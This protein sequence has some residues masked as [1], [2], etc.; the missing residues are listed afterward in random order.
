[1]VS[2]RIQPLAVVALRCWYFSFFLFLFV[3]LV[4]RDPE[5]FSLLASQT[6]TIP[7]YMFVFKALGEQLTLFAKAIFTTSAGPGYHFSHFTQVS[8]K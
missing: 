3:C 2:G 7:A 8:H 4:P 6:L 5:A 1:M